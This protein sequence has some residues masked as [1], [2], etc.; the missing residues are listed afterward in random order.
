MDAIVWRNSEPNV[1]AYAVPKLLLSWCYS[2]VESKAVLVGRIAG[3][4]GGKP[5]SRRGW[6][7]AQLDAAFEVS[8][9][10]NL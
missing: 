3:A 1:L 4:V 7:E 10:P 5:T 2:R 9:Q 6:E 8:S